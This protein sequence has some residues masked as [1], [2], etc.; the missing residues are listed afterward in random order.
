[1]WVGAYERFSRLVTSAEEK[2]FRLS[3]ETL[4][5]SDQEARGRTTEWWRKYTNETTNT[6]AVLAHGHQQD[7]VF[8][9]L[10]DKV[11]YSACDVPARS[12]NEDKMIT[13]CHYATLFGDLPARVDSAFLKNMRALSILDPD[14]CP[15]D[16][17]VIKRVGRSIRFMGRVISHT[18]SA[19]GTLVGANDE[20][21]RCA[22][23]FLCK[24]DRWP[25][26]DIEVRTGNPLMVHLSRF[27]VSV[28]YDVMFSTEKHKR[29]YARHDGIVSE[30]I[31]LDG[32]HKVL[33]SSTNLV[34]DRGEGAF[35]ETPFK[36]VPFR[37]SQSGIRNLEAHL[38]IPDSVLRAITKFEELAGYTLSSGA[39]S[40]FSTLYKDTFGGEHSYVPMDCDS[41][42]RVLVMGF[43]ANKRALP[44]TL[45]QNVLEGYLLTLNAFQTMDQVASYMANTD[46]LSA[47]QK[48]LS[49]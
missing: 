7:G 23:N 45:P 46:R 9:L 8:I 43:S 22:F 6:Q 31:A 39:V 21:K 49:R 28:P 24:Y 15:R 38:N 13:L 29:L 26:N 19:L 25:I 14:I 30:G 35:V 18:P 16:K 4:V 32:Y 27:G 5:R 2:G 44:L 48:T 3:T 42:N 34:F 11:L 40:V 1:M 37:P 47:R 41:I 33:V 12:I 20:Y 36:G 17:D 10:A